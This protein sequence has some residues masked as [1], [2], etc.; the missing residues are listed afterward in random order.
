MSQ[1][2]RACALLAAAIG[3]SAFGTSASADTLWDQ[4][5]LGTGTMTRASGTA[6]PGPGVLSPPGTQ[7]SELFLGNTS[8]GST[9][10][11]S[12]TTGIFR[13]ADNFTLAQG[14]QI[15]TVTARAYVTGSTDA[16]LFT[17]GN[18]RIWNG[19]PNAAGSTVVFGDTTT[20]RV[21]GSAVQPLYRIFSTNNSTQGGINSLPGT[22]R[23]IKTAVFDIGGLN[24]PAGTYW[25]DYQLVSPVS[26]TGAVF[27]PTVTLTDARGPA[28]ANALQLTTG[29]SGWVPVVDAGDPAA[30]PDIAQELAFSVEG[31]IPEPASLGLLAMGALAVL[32]RRRAH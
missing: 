30:N 23:R 28:G 12:G 2:Q 21:I 13:L 15:D 6:V 31:I 7:W 32:R 27:H 3:L 17:T 24:L 1:S 18:I 14:A 26:P 9:V 8:N 5:Q 20:D 16:Q 19:A 10:S 29:P 4:T 25:V 22:T 11:P